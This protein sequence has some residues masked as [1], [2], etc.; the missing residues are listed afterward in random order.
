[1][2]FEKAAEIIKDTKKPERLAGKWKTYYYFSQGCILQ[3]EYEFISAIKS[4]KKIDKIFLRTSNDL[5]LSYF[6]I[7]QCYFYLQDYIN[8]KKYINYAIETPHKSVLNDI[9]KT[10]STDINEKLNIK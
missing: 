2:N 3:N 5:C 8:A 10:S 6:H 7:A 9:L 4:Y 1:M